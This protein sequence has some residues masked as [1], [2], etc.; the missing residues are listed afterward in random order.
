MSAPETVK[1][2]SE[3]MP[4]RRDGKDIEGRNFTGLLA[5]LC[6]HCQL[7]GI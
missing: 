5:V 2:F 4:A 1:V 6:L 3:T 7:L